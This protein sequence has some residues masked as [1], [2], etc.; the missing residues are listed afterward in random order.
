M[1]VVDPGFSW[2]GVR[3]L[4]K[5]LLFFNFFVENCMKMKESGPPGG[6]GVKEHVKVYHMPNPR[7]P[8]PSPSPEATMIRIRILLSGNLKSKIFFELHKDSHTS[9]THAKTFGM[10]M[11]TV[12]TIL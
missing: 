9:E 5:V 3:Q 1:P 4:P 7:S 6:Q 12:Y 10:M 11:Q 2:G 8:F